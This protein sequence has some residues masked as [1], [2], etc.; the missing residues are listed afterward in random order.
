MPGRQTYPLRCTQRGVHRTSSPTPRRRAS[1][2]PFYSRQQG[3][4]PAATA[5]ARAAT[6]R[7]P[8]NWRTWLVLS[9][10]EA[11]RGTGWRSGPPLPQ[12]QI[13]QST[14][15]PLRSMTM[16]TPEEIRHDLPPD[17]PQAERET[18][19]ALGLRLQHQRPIPSPDLPGRSAK[20]ARR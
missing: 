20:D 15:S 17:L 10:V 18:L 8:T 11:E 16:P 3:N 12:G 1:S 2:R 14:L 7:E 13:A 5:A 6:Q 4:L 19:V 9:R